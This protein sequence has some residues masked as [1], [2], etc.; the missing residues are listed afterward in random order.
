M[1]DLPAA[2]SDEIGRRVHRRRRDRSRPSALA[3]VAGLSLHLAV[4]FLL[5]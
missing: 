5:V 3:W 2:E 4:V 1:R